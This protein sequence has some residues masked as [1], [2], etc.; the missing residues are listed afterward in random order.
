MGNLNDLIGQPPIS[1]EN[2]PQTAHSWEDEAG[3]E[4]EK[5]TD[6]IK[7][8]SC[9]ANMRF[10]PE[11]QAMFCDYCETV[12][13]FNKSQK[14]SERDFLLESS[15]TDDWSEDTV[16]IRCN[17]CGNSEVI[18]KTDIARVCPFCGTSN[19]IESNELP[20]IKPGVVLPFT[21][22][23]LQC[24]ETV[25]KWFKKKFFVPTKLRKSFDVGSLN[26][27]Y[28][29]VWSFDSNTVSKYQGRLGKYYTR[30]VHNGKNSYTV[31]EIKYF[32]VSGTVNRN[33]D[34][35]LIEA[36]PLLDTQ[37]FEQLRPFDRNCAVE[38]D[39]KYLSGFTANHYDKDIHVSFK[40][41]KK[42]MDDKIRSEI[43]SSYHADVV[44]FLNVNTY[45]SNVKFKYM[46]M[47]VWVGRYDYMKK[48]YNF[49][50]NG[51]S[52]K[53][54]GKVPRSGWK[55]LRFISILGACIAALAVGGYYL[56]DWLQSDGGGRRGAGNV[57]QTA[58]CVS[59]TEREQNFDAGVCGYRI[60]T[61]K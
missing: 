6:V 24:L 61:L 2:E 13:D 16:V 50:V 20:G 60:L 43:I 21:L 19:I 36:G 26:G 57:S 37:K 35:I 9:G 59:Q 17:N 41:A 54:I 53:T 58:F 29:P 12:I 45:H 31:T 34:D 48:N 40:E 38:Y 27:V 1:D 32:R 28:T 23:K 46:L 8:P 30:R 18:S 44:D 7:C 5:T 39:K 33:F 51:N 15:D 22:S 49:Y 25:K 4:I 10:A 52:G 42:I 3:K 55:I 56:Y 11:R 47:P 14:I